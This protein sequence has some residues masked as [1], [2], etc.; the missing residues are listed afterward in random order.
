MRLSE[1]WFFIFKFLTSI[2]RL[3]P[4]TPPPLLHK[5]VILKRSLWLRIQ[6]IEISGV[7][8]F[9][10]YALYLFNYYLFIKLIRNGIK[11]QLH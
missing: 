1:N 4:H 6:Y 11:C 2:R 3:K 10:F 9:R 8:S 7:F 5:H